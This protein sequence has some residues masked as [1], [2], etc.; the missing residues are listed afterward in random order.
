MK[1]R[2][3]NESA[4]QRSQSRG[5]QGSGYSLFSAQHCCICGEAIRRTAEWL[6]L[7]RELDGSVEY[8]ITHPEDAP[9]AMRV[10]NLWV[11]PIGPDCLRKHPELEPLLLR[12]EV[13]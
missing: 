6:L 4:Y 12:R 2:L 13:S 5:A 10:H 11:A 3:P 1:L 9:P 8:A 7:T